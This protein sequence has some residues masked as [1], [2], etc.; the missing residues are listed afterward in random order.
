MTDTKR[1]TDAADVAPRPFDEPASKPMP[2]KQEAPNYD[3][4]VEGGRA[5]PTED[6]NSA[7]DE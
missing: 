1:K 4:T 3:D 7:N 6:I 5:I 2:R